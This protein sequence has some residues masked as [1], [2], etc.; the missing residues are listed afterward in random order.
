MGEYSRRGATGSLPASASCHSSTRAG[1][2]QV[3]AELLES[4]FSLPVRVDSAC[5]FPNL[6]SHGIF[7]AEDEL[8]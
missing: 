4:E 1:R 5:V 7:R 6:K 8:V 2:C 3:G